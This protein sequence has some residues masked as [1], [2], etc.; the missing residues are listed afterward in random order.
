MANYSIHDDF[1]SLDEQKSVQEHCINA[2]YKWGETDTAITRPIGVVNEITGGVIH[3]LFRVKTKKIVEENKYLIEYKEE[4]FKLYRMY[5]SCMAPREMPYFHTD[6]P[7]CITLIYYPQPDSK[8]DDGGETQI[9]SDNKTIDGIL[10]VSN[11]IVILD[12]N[13]EY[14]ATS[15]RNR[16]RFTITIKYEKE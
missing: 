13:S 1:L 10:P 4:E 16:H 6:G 9:L 7:N 5:V 11:R 12:G 14:R 2:E 15:F 3:E 8:T